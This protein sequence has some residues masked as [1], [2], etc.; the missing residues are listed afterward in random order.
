MTLSADVYVCHILRL[1][2]LLSGNES[3]QKCSRNMYWGK[4]AILEHSKTR[5]Q[6]PWR[7]S[8]A[9]E[10]EYVADLLHL[11]KPCFCRNE[12]EWPLQCLSS[13]ILGHQRT[14]SEKSSEWVSR[15]WSYTDQ[16]LRPLHSILGCAPEDLLGLCRSPWRQE[17]HTDNREF[18]RDGHSYCILKDY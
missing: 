15:P 11:S 12:P 16:V 18:L 4:R 8:C 1:L 14:C 3:C 6:A 10:L 13:Q 9:I 7:S 5:R 2:W 17:Y